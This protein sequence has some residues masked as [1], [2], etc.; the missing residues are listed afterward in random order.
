MDSHIKKY[1]AECIG[2]FVLVFMGIGSAYFIDD[3]YLTGVGLVGVALAFGLSV[4]A[5]AYAIGPVSG[6][7]VNPAVSLAMLIRRKLSAVDFI[8]YLLAQC[9]GAFVAVFSLGAILGA[10][11]EI[12][13]ANDIVNLPNVGSGLAVEG[14]LTF[15]FVITILGVLS[16]K[17]NAPVAG[18]VIGLALTLVHI[19]GINMTGTSVN[20]IR[21][22]APA[23]YNGQTENLWVFIVGPFLGAALAA[24]A[25][26][27]FHPDEKETEK[28]KKKA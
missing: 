4:T 13:G 11:F 24:L 18:L 8:F 10:N 26:A 15:I 25:S 1:V 20:P 9:V 5:M 17:E 27:W 12:G 16:K 3:L 21:S 14:I 23:I 19:V 28:G 6:C 7:H 2:T 22:L